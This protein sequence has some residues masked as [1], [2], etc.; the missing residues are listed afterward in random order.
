MYQPK[1]QQVPDPWSELAFLNI[2][3]YLIL[4]LSPCCKDNAEYEKRNLAYALGTWFTIKILGYVG[5]GQNVSKPRLSPCSTLPADLQA[6]HL[7]SIGRVQHGK[8]TG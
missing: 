4:P 8:A 6:L 7:L 2:Y 1:E 3:N 5:K